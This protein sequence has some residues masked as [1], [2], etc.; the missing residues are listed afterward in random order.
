VRK[1]THNDGL[2]WTARWGRDSMLV[3]TV[4]QPVTPTVR[5]SYT[6][7]IME[8]AIDKVLEI[9]RTQP[10]QQR[11]WTELLS[12]CRS[13]E[14]SDLWQVLPTPDMERD[15]STATQWL[16]SQLATLP[17]ATGIY[18]GLDTLNMDDGSGTN[19][20][21]GGTAACD[22]SQD[23]IDWVY[24]KL[25]YGDNHLIRGLF[26]LQQVYS[27]PKWESAFSFA[28]YIL[29]LGYSGIILGQAFIR[30][31][32]SRSLLPAWGFHD[33]DLFA[34]GR[35]TPERFDFICK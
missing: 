13:S 32:T 16:S 10:D 15:I 27:Q 9:I 11:A 1:R 31:S 25:K 21:F 12:L 30:F 5:H 2:H 3:A 4:A 7:P 19:V 24:G 8:Q 29:L 18:L 26:E 28:D 17:D 35:K 20:E 6:T 14:P 34:L 23:Q 22:V 33:G